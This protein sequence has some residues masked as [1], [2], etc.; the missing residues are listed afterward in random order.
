[1]TNLRR[2]KAFIH[3]FYAEGMEDLQLD[4]AEADMRDLIS[5]YQ[6]NDINEE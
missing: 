1:M 5:D 2:K 3:Y 4:E 6:H